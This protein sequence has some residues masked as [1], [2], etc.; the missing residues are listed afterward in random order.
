V[1]TCVASQSDD[2]GCCGR[3]RSG[4]HRIRDP[5]A[6][7]C[8]CLGAGDSS[9]L[10]SAGTVPPCGRGS[11]AVCFRTVGR[12]SHAALVLALHEG[13]AWGPQL[14]TDSRVNRSGALGRQIGRQRRPKSKFRYMRGERNKQAYQ[15]PPRKSPAKRAEPRTP[16]G[17]RCSPQRENGRWALQI[18]YWNSDK[19]VAVRVRIRR[20]EVGCIFL[21][22]VCVILS[23]LGSRIN[24]AGSDAFL[25]LVQLIVQ[26]AL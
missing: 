16:R 6:P 18:D 17:W 24:F 12:N 4:A 25:R 10:R 15:T 8:R 23:L 7:Q 21:A 19:K 1:V 13:R 11:R 5:R 2:V 22:F 9:K 3:G 20:F 14:V 26:T